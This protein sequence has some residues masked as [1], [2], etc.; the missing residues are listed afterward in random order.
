MQISIDFIFQRKTGLKKKNLTEDTDKKQI[1]NRF[2]KMPFQ[3]C[4]FSWIQ[5]KSEGTKKTYNK[6]KKSSKVRGGFMSDWTTKI[7]IPPW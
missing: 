6:T 7:I 4:W 1:L 5:K 2:I 3:S